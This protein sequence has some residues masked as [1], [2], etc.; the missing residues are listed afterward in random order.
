MTVPV[1]HTSPTPTLPS[2]RTRP[3]DNAGLAPNPH[4]HYDGGYAPTPA[5]CESATRAGT[6]R[7]P[8]QIPGHRTTPAYAPLAGR[9]IQC[10]D[11]GN[12][13]VPPADLATVGGGHRADRTGTG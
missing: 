4:R 11:H 9:T 2:Q 12:L 3:G 10:H 1:P 13:H 6:A 5:H 7:P 8:R